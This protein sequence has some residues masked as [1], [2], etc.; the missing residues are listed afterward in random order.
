MGHSIRKVRDLGTQAT[1]SA[2]R[3]LPSI[4]PPFLNEL[5]KVT[6]RA[7]GRTGADAVVERIEEI[8]FMLVLIDDDEPPSQTAW[9]YVK[10]VM[11]CLR[12]HLDTS[13]DRHPPDVHSSTP[14]LD[15]PVAAPAPGQ[16]SSD[17][18][19]AIAE[20]EALIGLTAVK[21]D[22]SSL[23]NLVR[24]QQKRRE[25]GLPVSMSLHL[26]FTGN[27]GTGKTTVA[28]L[29]ARIYQCLGVLSK[30]HLVP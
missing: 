22:V 20:L 6:A 24:V 17:L 10:S 14:A 28:R 21:R 9:E 11:S 2:Y 23:A 16:T 1:R 3:D 5:S 27:P 4:L 19:R 13:F 12:G 8:C 26:V 30:G 18:E 29:I 25:A 7:D 15:R